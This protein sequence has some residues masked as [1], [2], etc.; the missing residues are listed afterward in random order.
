MFDEN[1]YIQHNISIADGLDVLGAALESLA[2]QGIQII[3]DKVH[4]VLASGDYALEISE[5]IFRGVK[6]TYCDLWR[7]EDGK[8]REYWD[9]MGTLMSK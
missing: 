9:V 4:Y 6:T 7:V 1:N 2:K 3:Y 8:I 5:E